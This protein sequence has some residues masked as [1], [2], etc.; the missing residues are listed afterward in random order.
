M[1]NQGP[2]SVQIP[3][4]VSILNI[5]NA[6]QA[7]VKSNSTFVEFVPG[8]KVKI[9][10]G[11]GMDGLLDSS[12]IFEVMQSPILNILT[13]VKGTPLVVSTKTSHGFTG[14]DHVAFS[15]FTGNWSTLNNIPVLVAATPSS[16]A[17]EIKYIEGDDINVTNFDSFSGQENA[18]VTVATDSFVLNLDTST[19]DHFIHSSAAPA[20]A[21]LD[22]SLFHLHDVDSSH[23]TPLSA[24]GGT[25]VSKGTVISDLE[26]VSEDEFVVTAIGHGLWPRDVVRFTGMETVIPSNETFRLKEV[27][28]SVLVITNISMSNPAVV[29]APGHGLLSADEISIH[30]CHGL[31][32]LNGGFFTVGTV[33]T[34]DTFTL[35]DFA[36]E[37]VDSTVLSPYIAGGNIFFA[38][39]K[40]TVQDS[41]LNL[42]VYQNQTKPLGTVFAINQ[43]QA[44]L[45]GLGSV[46]NV[47]I[48]VSAS[49][50]NDWAFATFSDLKISVPY[51]RQG[52]PF[53]LEFADTE[54]LLR[55][56]T[57]VFWVWMSGTVN[58]TAV[59][60]SREN[61]AVT[62]EGC[63][64]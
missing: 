26:I 54:N 22:S 28:T 23:F 37:N 51:W 44:T 58:L 13:V 15:G 33:L 45:A 42:P 48:S 39:K 53:A 9:V 24:Y 14:G 32:E 11:S 31:T 10:G 46:L 49:E 7:I 64:L 34:T 2:F 1:T 43:K 62:S 38:G 12:D 8:D 17:L 35:R 21:T 5:S 57:G 30:D 4:N 41:K 40:I 18:T 47:P 63:S 25:I 50:N 27:D 55:A 60:H 56:R 16:T 52:G 19:T 36:G 3:Q 59:C 29:T 20:T 6:P 61:G